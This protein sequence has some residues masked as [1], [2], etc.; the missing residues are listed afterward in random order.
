MEYAK[1]ISFNVKNSEAKDMGQIR[2]TNLM[3]K[4]ILRARKHKLII[5]I[6]AITILMIIF[7]CFLIANFINILSTL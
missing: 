7:D 3:T 5:S 1:D 6:V 4:C 2:R